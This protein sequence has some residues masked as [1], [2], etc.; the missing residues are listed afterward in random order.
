M[1]E[2]KNWTSSAMS[3][4][5]NYPECQELLYA[6]NSLSLNNSPEVYMEY[7]SD[8]MD[9]YQFFLHQFQEAKPYTMT[10]VT[11]YF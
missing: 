1:N 10:F 6:M 4:Y 2:A 8:A 3:K 5:T 11:Y 7:I 9:L